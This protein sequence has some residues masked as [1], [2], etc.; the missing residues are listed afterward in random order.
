VVGTGPEGAEGGI[1]LLKLLVISL[2]F[3]LTAVPAR[4]NGCPPRE[5]KLESTPG[6]SEAV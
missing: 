2:L 3:T 4:G 1:K 6:S 5:S